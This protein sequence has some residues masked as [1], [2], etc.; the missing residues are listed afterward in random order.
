VAA[1]SELEGLVMLDTVSTVLLNMEEGAS[2]QPMTGVR[3]R[4]RNYPECTCDDNLVRR[5]NIN[6]CCGAHASLMSPSCV[7]RAPMANLLKLLLSTRGHLPL[8]R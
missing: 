6:L 1:G 3:I 5:S 7:L 2:P 4:N 8:F